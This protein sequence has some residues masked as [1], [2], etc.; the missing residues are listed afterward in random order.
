MKSAEEFLSA[1]DRGSRGAAFSTTR[2]KPLVSLLTELRK[3]ANRGLEIFPVPEIAQWTR[4]PELLIREATLEISRLEELAAMYPLCTWRAAVGPS[5]FCVVRLE[6]SVGRAW[7]ASNNEDQGDC[8]TLSTAR[9]GLVWA[10]FRWP[11]GLVLRAS[12][13]ALAPGVRILTDG[14]SFPIPP[15][16][17][18]T[19]ADPSAEIEE[20]PHWLRVEAF[21]PPDSPPKKSAQLPVALSRRVPCR[22]RARLERPHRNTRNGHSNCSQATW[23]WGW[24]V[25]RR[26]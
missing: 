6:E 11:S 1:L 3:T 22:P 8:R 19:W 2:Q 13:K 17:G 7:F 4:H 5:R 21:E 24:H 12:A 25:Y 16:R 20:V 23:R 18:S 14:E 10:I 26:R 15:S 9:G